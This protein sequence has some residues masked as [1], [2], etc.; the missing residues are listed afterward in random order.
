[1]T[2]VRILSTNAIHFGSGIVITAFSYSAT[3]FRPIKGL[4]HALHALFF[5]T[6]KVDENKF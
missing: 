1:M 4:I 5:E 6:M 3:G 2:K